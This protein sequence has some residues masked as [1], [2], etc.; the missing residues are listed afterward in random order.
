MLW[1]SFRSLEPTHHSPRELN[2]CRQG[3]RHLTA[4]LSPRPKTLCV[5]NSIGAH[6]HLPDWT[7]TILFYRCLGLAHARVARLSLIQIRLH[8]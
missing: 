1:P 4:R 3:R 6:P 5:R 8:R 2:N 7:P